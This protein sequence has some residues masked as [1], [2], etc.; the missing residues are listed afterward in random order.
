MSKKPGVVKA[1]SIMMYI[2][3]GLFVFAMPG[4]KPAA[5]IFIPLVV[6]LAYGLSSLKASART[7]TIAFACFGLLV[8]FG[9]YVS[10]KFVMHGVLV[11]VAF[12][13]VVLALLLSPSARNAN[14]KRKSAT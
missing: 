9:A 2:M 6:Y 10:S 1:A 3:A 4:G 8:N 12:Y 11:D 13:V 14:W 7:G 5:A